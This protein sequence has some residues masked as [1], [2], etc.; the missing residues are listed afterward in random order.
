MLSIWVVDKDEK[1]VGEIPIVDLLLHKGSTLVRDI[2]EPAVASVGP[3]EDQETVAQ[4]FR[5][6]DLISLPVVDENKKLLGRIVVDDVVDVITDE[7]NE[8]A[9]KM[10]GTSAE[11]LYTVLKFYQ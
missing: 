1:L 10:A 5:K 4:I 6:Y 7:A 9:L 2:C 8:D 3:L 11:E